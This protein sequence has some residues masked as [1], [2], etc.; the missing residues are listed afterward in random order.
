MIGLIYLFSL[1]FFPDRVWWVAVASVVSVVVNF[2]LP[3]FSL[4]DDGILIKN[5]VHFFKKQLEFPDEDS[6]EFDLLSK[7]LQ[8]RVGKLQPKS[9]QDLLQWL[10]SFDPD[11]QYNIRKFVGRIVANRPLTFVKSFLEK[12]LDEMQ[13]IALDILTEADDD[14]DELD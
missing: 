14:D 10:K 12:I 5:N 2:P 6:E 3:L 8:K 1:T 11:N 4:F 13:Q 7:D 9:H